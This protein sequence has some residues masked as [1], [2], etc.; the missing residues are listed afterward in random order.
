MGLPNKELLVRAKLEE[1]LGKEHV[2]QQLNV[3][4][5]YFVKVVYLNKYNQRVHKYLVTDANRIPKSPRDAW[6]EAFSYLKK[7]GNSIDSSFYKFWGA[8]V[9]VELWLGFMFK[10]T[11]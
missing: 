4:R 1:L 3:D 11:T 8:I 10:V 9:E 5:D 7:H 2:V 6:K